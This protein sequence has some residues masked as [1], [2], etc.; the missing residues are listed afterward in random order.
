VTQLLRCDCEVDGTQRLKR[1]VIVMQRSPSSI[2]RIL[3]LLLHTRLYF[4]IEGASDA[5]NENIKRLLPSDLP[6]A[7][8]QS[9]GRFVTSLCGGGNKKSI[10]DVVHWLWTSKQN[11]LSLPSIKYH[12]RNNIKIVNPDYNTIKNRNQTKLTWVRSD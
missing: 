2:R 5:I 4:T 12:D 10:Q 3:P 9:N 7:Y 11:R 8:K 6:K 1:I